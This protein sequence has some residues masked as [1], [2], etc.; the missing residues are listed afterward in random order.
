MIV[1]VHQQGKTGHV[2]G[3]GGVAL[4]AQDGGQ[5]VEQLAAVAAHAERVAA[6]VPVAARV[7][8]I[9]RLFISA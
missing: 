7:C 6:A 5:G 8:S 4:G 1:G 9:V 3:L 2:V